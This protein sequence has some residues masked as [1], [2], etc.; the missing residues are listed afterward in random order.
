ME[1]ENGK[2]DEHRKISG[3]MKKSV[4]TVRPD[5]K[6]RKV[7]QLMSDRNISCVVITE[8]KKPVGIVTER[9]I[10]KKVVLSGMD[11][12]ENSVKEIMS[13]ELITASPESDLI[14]T[15]RYMKRKKIRRFPVTNENGNLV[16]L[17]TETDILEGIISLVKFLDWKL[18]KMRISVADYLQKLKDTKFL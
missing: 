12:D 2:Y 10:L 9:D 3:V 14:P 16:G 8:G 15:G 18:V 17:V 13:T 5:A 6:V 1:K 7:V 11:I 4:K